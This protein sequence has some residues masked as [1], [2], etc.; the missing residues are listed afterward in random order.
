LK[1]VEVL[2]RLATEIAWFAL[3]LRLAD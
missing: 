3:P 1:L 2:H